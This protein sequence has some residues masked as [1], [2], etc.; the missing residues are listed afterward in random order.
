M[1]D[2]ELIGIWLEDKKGHL[3]IVHI[4]HLLESFFKALRSGVILF[5]VFVN[6]ILIVSLWQEF[7]DSIPTTLSDQIS[8]FLLS[9]R[10][11]AVV[12]TFWFKNRFSNFAPILLLTLLLLGLPLTPLFWGIVLDGRRYPLKILTRLGNSDQTL[13][14]K[15]WS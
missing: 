4:L 15:L 1:G 6:I 10:R 9:S 3:I 12:A 7:L 14:D 8:H 5:L 11:V 2:S 13:L